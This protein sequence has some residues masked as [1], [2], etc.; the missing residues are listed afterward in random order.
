M[1]D[2]LGA[3]SR[4]LPLQLLFSLLQFSPHVL[5]LHPLLPVHDLD[6][7]GQFF[8]LGKTLQDL[9]V[10]LLKCGVDGCEGADVDSFD[11]AGLG[12]QAELLQHEGQLLRGGFD[13][14]EEF[15]K[16]AES[17]DAIGVK[18]RVDFLIVNDMLELEEQG[19]YQPIGHLVV[20][21]YRQGFEEMRRKGLALH[22][23]VPRY[24][25]LRQ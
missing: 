18:P 2:I 8:A 5:R 25:T 6:V 24:H 19:H 22:R 7:I 20:I 15:L 23:P 4:S 3:E 21:D 1:G 10:Y 9:G 12:L 14:L 16:E 13:Y 17:R 11:L